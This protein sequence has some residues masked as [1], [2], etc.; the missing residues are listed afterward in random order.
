MLVERNET[1]FEQ[2]KHDARELVD[3][4]T[5]ETEVRGGKVNEAHLAFGRPDAESV[6][7]GEDLEAG[8]V[9]V[10]SR[11]SGEVRRALLGG[12]SN[13]MVGHAHGPVLVAWSG[14]GRPDNADGTPRRLERSR[15]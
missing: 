12:V 13:S 2:A 6:K 9:V 5:K 3:W 15:E 8:L 1:I 7:L 10:G 11:G 4:R 14:D